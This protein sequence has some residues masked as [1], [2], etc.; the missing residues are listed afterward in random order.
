MNA[1][2]ITATFQVAIPTINHHVALAES[3]VGGGR[4]A[5]AYVHF[6]IENDRVHIVTTNG[7]VMLHT[8]VKSGDGF[9][10]APITF[11]VR[12]MPRVTA[13]KADAS[14]TESTAAFFVV[15]DGLITSGDIMARIAVDIAYPKWRQ[16]LPCR[17]CLERETAWRSLDPKYYALAQKFAGRDNYATAH[18]IQGDA[19]GPVVFFNT[20]ADGDELNTAV[21]MPLREV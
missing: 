3:N 17:A 8:E 21:V 11:D 15:K 13:K 4:P 9:V 10:E 1:K 6:E 14:V 19:H 5:L 20:L 16:T 12:S 18:C 2:E 7:R